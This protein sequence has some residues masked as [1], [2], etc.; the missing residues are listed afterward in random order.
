MSKSSSAND[1][2]DNILKVAQAEAAEEGAQ[3]D[4][5]RAIVDDHVKVAGV[6]SNRRME[7]QGGQNPQQVQSRGVSG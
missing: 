1:Y 5:Y 4:T 2:F 7:K 6:E 3:L